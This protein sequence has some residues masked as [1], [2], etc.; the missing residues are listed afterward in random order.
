MAFLLY[1]EMG[2][3]VFRDYVNLPWHISLEFQM[4]KG[5]QQLVFLLQT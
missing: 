3:D 1:R 5:R 4:K 2:G